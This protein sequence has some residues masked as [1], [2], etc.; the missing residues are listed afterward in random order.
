[1]SFPV[2]DLHC[3]TALALLGEDLRSPTDLKKNKLH[4]DLD[5]AKA[6]PGYAQFFACFT[7]PEMKQWYGISPE[8]VFQLELD[9]ILAALESHKRTISQAFCVSDILANAQKGKMSAVLSIEGPAGFG[10]DPE[11]L[12]QLYAVGFRMTTLGWNEQNPL[13]GSHITG[14][15]LTEQGRDY[16]F[17]AQRLGM[18]VDVSHCSDEAFFDMLEIAEKPIIASHSNSRAVCGVGRNLTDDMFKAICQVGGVAGINLYTD[19]IG[20]GKDLDAVCRH[21]GHF[22]ELDPCGQHISLGGDLDGC[23]S[24]AAGFEGVQDYPKIALALQAAGADDTIIRNIFWNN[25]IGVMEK[26]CM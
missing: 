26:C 24:L 6:L 1:M 21:I 19:F 10:Y 11:L 14:G 18:I 23:E 2:F 8:M 9:I 7:T 13:C 3:D 22:L 25:A 4:I 15:G 5:R 20:G 17:E 12:E 16:F